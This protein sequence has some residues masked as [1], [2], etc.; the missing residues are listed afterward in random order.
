MATESQVLQ[1]GVNA[2]NFL[3][4]PAVL[5]LQAET[6][7]DTSADA[8]GGM[9]R[10]L[11]DVINVTNGA[12][13]TANG[14]EYIGYTE[15]INP[16]RN[17]TIVQLDSDQEAQVKS[18]HDTWENTLTLTALETT[19][20]KYQEFWQG[21]DDDP[22]SVAD[23]P[24]AQQ[25]VRIG[26]SSDINYRRVAIVKIDDSG[27]AW[28][29]IY[30]KCVVRPTGG[31]TFSRTGRVEQPLEITAHPDTRVSDVDDRVLR[32]YKTDASIA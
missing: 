17:R 9:P 16:G 31:P 11:D 8:A 19:L 15:N 30:R 2:D 12:A 3:F 23:A 21:D 29:Y 13:M 28:C 14:W 10:Y 22:S 32:I 5:L 24:T 20:S 18:V 4:G 7:Y 25:Q 27:K 1:S 26:N 6:N